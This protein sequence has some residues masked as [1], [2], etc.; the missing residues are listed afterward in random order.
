MDLSYEG[1]HLVFRGYFFIVA[2]IVSVPE[3]GLAKAIETKTQV[4]AFKLATVTFDES[5]DMP[6]PQKFFGLTILAV[7]DFLTSH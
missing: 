2:F 7:K 6:D 1:I 5:S 3:K 4:N